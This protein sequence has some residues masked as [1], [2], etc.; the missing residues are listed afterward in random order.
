[1][2]TLEV[3]K[4]YISDK[5]FTYKVVAEL[6]RG[7]TRVFGAHGTQSRSEI[8]YF[9]PDGKAYYE[10]SCSGCLIIPKKK[11]ESWLVMSSAGDTAVFGKLATAEQWVAEHFKNGNFEIIYASVEFDV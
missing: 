4:E 7:D 8:R 5:G 10:P 1:M 9:Y 2:K 6:K 11:V 3:G